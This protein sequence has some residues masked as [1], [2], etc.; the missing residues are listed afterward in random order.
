[1]QLLA[2]Q[3]MLDTFDT[4]GEGEML[5]DDPLI[6]QQLYVEV[7]PDS[8][9]LDQIGYYNAAWLSDESKC[10]VR[11]RGEQTQ[12]KSS[13]AHEYVHFLQDLHP[14]GSFGLPPR[15]LRNAREV[16]YYLKDKEFY[17]HIVQDL[18]R[19]VETLEEIP[20]EDHT[21]AFAYF[22]GA[23]G[24]L[25]LY[26]GLRTIHGDCALTHMRKARRLEPST[27]LLNLKWHHRQKWR[28]AVKKLATY[29]P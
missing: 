26:E 6:G 25:S 1:M 14:S 17:A 9:F 5:W 3:D 12:R 7:L 28:H 8:V 10:V 18:M 15:R 16:H 22:V 20:K 21:L 24:R 23:V 11:D 2:P 27:F 19:M 13:L 4:F 29:L